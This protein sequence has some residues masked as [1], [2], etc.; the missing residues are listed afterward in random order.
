MYDNL[1]FFKGLEYDLNFV[2]DNSDVYQG[3]VHLSEVSAGLYET[4]NLFILEECELFG[5]PIINFPVSETPDNDKF[6]FEWSEDTRF[7]SKD[8]TLYNIDHSGNLPVIKELK[9][10]TIDLIDFSKV[11]V[12]NDGTKALWEQDST[13]IQINIALNSLKAGPHV[14][15]LHI[16]H[17]AAGVKTLIADI[18][19]YGEV[20]AEDERTK[21]LLQNFG[22]TLDESD[23]MLF[24]DHDISEMSPDYK[25][26]NKKRKELL[27]ELH[28]IKPFVG[29]YKAILNA[30]DFFGYD[31]ITLKEYWLNVN[32]S[33]KNFGKLFAVPVP[34]S[35]VRGEN[36][37]KKLAFK[38]P[39]STM[40]KTSKFS[41]VYRLNE[42]NGT[43]D[44]W[45][46]P[47]VDEVFDY[48]PE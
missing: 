34:N 42:P 17:S 5:D 19:V 15:N 13:A 26:L 30:I 12:F 28:N 11:A 36:T 43:F 46:I 1:R 9:S 44:H 22:A 10:Q 41:L 48:T 27:L 37:R 23:F 32:N 7:G 40:K 14:R 18:E 16:Y 35:S 39:S 24:K 33:V 20:V 29:T 8:I 25:L 21:I 38:L 2:K 4:I 45:D 3:T 31:K 6:I 47:N